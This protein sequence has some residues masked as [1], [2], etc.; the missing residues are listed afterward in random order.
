[1]AKKQKRTSEKERYTYETFKV[2]RFWVLL[3]KNKSIQY[4][5][6]T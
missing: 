4:N 6:N 3:D 5:V 2:S 1:M